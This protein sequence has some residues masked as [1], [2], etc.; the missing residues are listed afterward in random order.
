MRRVST[1]RTASYA[2]LYE[3]LEPGALLD[4]AP[5]G[6][7]SY[8]LELASPDHFREPVPARPS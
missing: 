3:H 6:T 2:E 1:T 5:P 8:W 7:W 4:G